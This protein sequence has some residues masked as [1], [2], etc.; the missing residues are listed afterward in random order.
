MKFLL[1]ILIFSITLFLYIHILFHLNTSN[2]L[3]I[4]QLNEPN[5]EKLEEVC[6]LKQPVLWEYP[7]ED[8]LKV[9][10]RKNLLDTYG[11]FDIK[12]RKVKYDLK[13]NEEMYLPYSLANGLEAIDKDKENKYIL[14]NNSDFIEETGLY[15]IFKLNDYLM[16][17]ALVSNIYYDIIFGNNT[18]TVFKYDL[19]YRN[20]L[21]VTEGEIKLKLSPPK[22]TKYLDQIQ[23][24]E[25]FEFRS[26]INPWNTKKQHLHNFDKIKCLEVTLKPKNIIYIP[27]HWWYSI[28]F[29]SKSTIASFKY[30]TLM[31][32]ISI[33]P[34]II[35]GIL[36]NQNIKRK[37]TN[38][39]N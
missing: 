39:V 27:P 17:P 3:E 10:N 8:L 7:N 28:K 12:I 20:Y 26:P 35:K 25:N 18:E 5:K 6:D 13:N 19:N 1:I 4:Y 24:Y 37:I 29:I 21:M 9:V 2:D 32:N 30:R 16:R 23:D 34:H 15:K 36:Q 33:S 14:E 38:I 22:G 31:N 11:A